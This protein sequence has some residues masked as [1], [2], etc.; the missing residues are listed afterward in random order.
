[1]R[2]LCLLLIVLIAPLLSPPG[3]A[4]HPLGNF[5]IN[6]YSLLQV[7][8]GSVRVTFVLAMAEIPTF[9]TFGGSADAASARTYILRQGPDLARR[10]RLT[11]NESV[12]PLVPDLSGAREAFQ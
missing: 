12:V 10:L 2:R 11:V 9:Q 3:A 7:D 4:A 6:R 1:M 5:T 8:R